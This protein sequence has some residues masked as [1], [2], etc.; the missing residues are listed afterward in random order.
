MIKNI[1]YGAHLRAITRQSCV[2][3]PC[4][5]TLHFG[6]SVANHLE[7]MLKGLD[8]YIALS[9]DQSDR[10]SVGKHVH[11]GSEFK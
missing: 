10:R 3:N 4:T 8:R 2:K 7:L 5:G 1:W 11:L 6:L 9:K